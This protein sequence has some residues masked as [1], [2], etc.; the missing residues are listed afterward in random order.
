MKKTKTN[1]LT[2]TFLFWGKF[3]FAFKSIT[4]SAVSTTNEMLQV[5]W[6]H[7]I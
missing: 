6:G 7:N 1:L 4:S 2:G 5:A 3:A